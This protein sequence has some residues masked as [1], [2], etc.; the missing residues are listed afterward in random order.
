MLKLRLF[1]FQLFRFEKAMTKN[2][3]DT[4]FW[5]NDLVLSLDSYLLA[6]NQLLHPP[7]LIDNSCFY[8]SPYHTKIHRG[9]VILLPL[10]RWML[11][12][13]Q[14]HSIFSHSF[15]TIV[16]HLV[17]HLVI[18]P[19][20]VI[21]A[22]V[23]HAAVQPPP[24]TLYTLCPPCSTPSCPFSPTHHSHC[25]LKDPHNLWYRQQGLSTCLVPEK[26]R[27]HYW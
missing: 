22:A 15:P 6:N 12:S 9:L 2:C 17:A 25:D 13:K 10:Y 8:P 5:P 1:S 23:T 14:H 16:S 7:T 20:A 11:K 27:W 19:T 21:Y 4:N 26:I 18:T 24:Y 3:S